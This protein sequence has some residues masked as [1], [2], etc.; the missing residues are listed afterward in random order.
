MYHSAA[1]Q[2]G[3]GIKTKL[4]VIH[5]P[6]S[7]LKDHFAANDNTSCAG[8]GCQVKTFSQKRLF[9]ILFESIGDSG[10]VLKVFDTGNAHNHTTR[11]A[12][13]AVII[14]SVKGCVF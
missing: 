14:C 4:N 1:R 6:N 10:L 8:C 3:Q 2:S 13:N 12:H 9:K 11:L 5:Q 7:L